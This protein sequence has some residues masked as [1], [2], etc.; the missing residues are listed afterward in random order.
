MRPLFEGAPRFLQRLAA[1]R[2]FGSTDRRF[3]A[4]L[5]IALSMPRDERIELVNA[6]PRLGASAGSVSALSF[7]EQGY[8]APEPVDPAAVTELAQLND[9]Y[10]QR[11]GFRYCVYVAGR[12]REALLPAMRQSLDNDG[13]AELERAVRSVVDIARD[14]YATQRHETT[15]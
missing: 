3:D 10:E 11:F 12:S 5:D 7:R 14:R 15:A 2:P 8:D 4:A 6:H 1:A 9:A 13:S